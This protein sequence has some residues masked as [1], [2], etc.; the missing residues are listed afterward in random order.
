MLC[1]SYALDKQVNSEAHGHSFIAHV[2]SI[3]QNHDILL[4]K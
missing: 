1:D 2:K 3:W 4:N